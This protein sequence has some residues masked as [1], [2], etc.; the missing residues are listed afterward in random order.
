MERET[1]ASLQSTGQTGEHPDRCKMPCPFCTV[2]NPDN[3]PRLWT[4]A[5]GHHEDR[6]RAYPRLR[7]S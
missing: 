2:S 4:F 3:P 5:F 1:A 6:S 7:A